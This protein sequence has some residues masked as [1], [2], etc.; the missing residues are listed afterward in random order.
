MFTIEKLA[1]KSIKGEHCSCPKNISKRYNAKLS[2][3]F[4]KNGKDCTPYDG[5]E[6]WEFKHTHSHFDAQA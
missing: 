3:I 1:S 4:N 5:W 6:A 2:R